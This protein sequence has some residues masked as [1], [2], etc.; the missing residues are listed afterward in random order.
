MVAAGSFRADLLYRLDAFALRVPPLRERVEEVVALALHVLASSR[1]A[2]EIS[3]EAC[4]ALRAYWWPGNVRHLRN[5]IE[6]AAAICPGGTIKLDD[7]PDDLFEHASGAAT[8]GARSPD[9]SYSLP[10]RLRS[11][12]AAAIREVLDKASGNQSEAA[13]LLGVPRRTLANR[14][15]ALGLAKRK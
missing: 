4:D 3:P 15:H 5:V 14:V 12:E 2:T 13:R 11:L 1:S 10:H 6:R 7:L 8:D 9:G